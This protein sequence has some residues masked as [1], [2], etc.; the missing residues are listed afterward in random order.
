M[1]INQVIGKS[2]TDTEIQ[3]VDFGSSYP[4]VDRETLLITGVVDGYCPA[5]LNGGHWVTG[6]IVDGEVKIGEHY[7][8]FAVINEQGSFALMEGVGNGSAQFFGDRNWHV[9]ERFDSH[10]EAMAALEAADADERFIVF[11]VATLT[12]E[13][14]WTLTFNDGGNED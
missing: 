5:E 11:N 1:D 6:A 13:G 2:I 9:V 8:D 14:V 3:G 4:V 10:E 12:S 7:C